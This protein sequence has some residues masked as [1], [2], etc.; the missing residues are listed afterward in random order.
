MLVYVEIVHKY[1]FFFLQFS[2]LVQGKGACKDK[3]CDGKTPHS[4]SLR[5]VTYFANFQQNKDSLFI[6]SPGGLDSLK[7]NAKKSHDTAT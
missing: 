3:M 1:S 6:R 4:V 7:K 2:I 5:G